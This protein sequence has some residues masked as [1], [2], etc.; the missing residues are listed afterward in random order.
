MSRAETHA[1]V[2][3]ALAELGDDALARGL[4]PAG[5]GIGGTTATMEVDGT[6]V[7]VKTVPLTER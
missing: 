4:Q 7:F 6:R 3:A 5:T 2:A 1:R